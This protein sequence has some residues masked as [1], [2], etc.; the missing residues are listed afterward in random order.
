MTSQEQLFMLF[1][2]AN[3]Q[4]KIPVKPPVTNIKAWCEYFSARVI[5]AQAKMIIVNEFNLIKN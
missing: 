3:K 1:Q 2:N 5:I 4:A